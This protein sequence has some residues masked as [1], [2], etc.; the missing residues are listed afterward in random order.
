MSESTGKP[1]FTIPPWAKKPRNLAIAGA[2]VVVLI[3]A[4][5]WWAI[6]NSVTN[7]GNQKESDLVAAY[8][9]GAN[10]LSNCVIK[11]NQ[12][13]NVA[14]ANAA[15]FDKVIKDAIAGSG[16][17]HVDTAQT[18][19]GLVP[20]LVQA[21]PQLQGQTDLYNKVADTII[22]CQD[23]FRSKQSTVLDQV[24]SFNRWRTGSWTV[25]HFG[26]DFPNDNLVINLPGV[27]PLTGKAALLKMGQPIIDATTS[28]S[29][30][31][32]Q[33]STQGPFPN[34]SPSN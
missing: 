19:G 22:G 20:I 27:Q 11:T 7:T 23:D 4:I 26:S 33:Q 17:F 15:A 34:G 10:Y 5:V 3:F 24:R 2:V 30:Q 25:R 16:A 21:Y 14:Q 13:A 9:D 29:Y 12:V 18:K 8:N 1:S 28:G 31:T 6:G 32:G